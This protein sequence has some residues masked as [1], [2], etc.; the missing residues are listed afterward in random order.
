MALMARLA[1]E[2]DENT[3]NP[4]LGGWGWWGGDGGGRDDGDDDP[5]LGHDCRQS[6]LNRCY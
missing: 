2:G 4:N 5:V 6:S 3:T 1:S